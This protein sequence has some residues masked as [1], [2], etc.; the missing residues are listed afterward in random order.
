VGGIDLK[1]VRSCGRPQAERRG[2]ER[3]TKRLHGMQVID[4]PWDRNKTQIVTDP[5]L[6]RRPLSR[7]PRAKKAAVRRDWPTPKL[8]CS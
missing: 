8:D 6:S 2:D 4:F 7:G 5:L 3:K 1:G